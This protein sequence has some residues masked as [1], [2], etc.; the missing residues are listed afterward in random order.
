MLYYHEEPPTIRKNFILSRY[1]SRKEILEIL[2]VPEGQLRGWE[3]KGWACPTVRDGRR[4]LY[5]FADVVALRTIQAL[6]AKRIGPEVFLTPLR[7]LQR[8]FLETDE[9]CES[10]T[11]TLLDDRVILGR[12]NHLIDGAA[13]NVL[14]RIDLQELIDR[15]SRSQ[16]TGSP[17]RTDEEWFREGVRLSANLKTA[18]QAIAAYREALKLNPLRADAY[19]DIGK[20][21]YRQRNLVDAERLL[22]MAIL[23]DPYNSGAH[24]MLGRVMDSLGCLEDAIA[25]YQRALAVTPRFT[26][27]HYRLARACAAAGQ[28]DKAIRHFQQYLALGPDGSRAEALRRELEALQSATTTE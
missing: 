22:R 6:V 21:H 1:F 23:R 10:K 16:G 9:S 4:V 11:V 20:I 27:A 3:R 8:R 5:S 25:F 26:D 2:A 13:A 7:L 28:I 17:G 12:A 19:L 18:S 15:V 24:Y 14:V